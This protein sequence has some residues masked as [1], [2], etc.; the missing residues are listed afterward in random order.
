MGSFLLKV[1]DHI[2]NYIRLRPE[3]IGS[4]DFEIV[5]TDPQYGPFSISPQCKIEYL[6]MSVS[7]KARAKLPNGGWRE[8]SYEELLQ[9]LQQYDQ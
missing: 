2:I 9:I 8:I 1:N 3:T 6:D 7:K 5:I 4:S